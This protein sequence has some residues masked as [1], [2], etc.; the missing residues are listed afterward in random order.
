MTKS[1]PVNTDNVNHT[2]VNDID[3]TTDDNMSKSANILTHVTR[4]VEKVFYTHPIL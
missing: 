3:I 4:F 2:P 1:E